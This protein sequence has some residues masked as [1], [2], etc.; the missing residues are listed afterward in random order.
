MVCCWYSQGETTKSPSSLMEAL[1]SVVTVSCGDASVMLITSAS[2]LANS[3]ASMPTQRTSYAMV[4]M[5]SAVTLSESV[6]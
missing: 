1:N 5:S 6:V 2:S 3:A 4:V